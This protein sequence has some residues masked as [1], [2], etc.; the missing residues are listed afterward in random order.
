VIFSSPRLRALGTGTATL[1]LSATLLVATTTASAAQSSPRFSDLDETVHAE[2]IELVAEDGITSGYPDGTFRPREDVRRDQMAT[3]LA[4]ALRLERQASRFPDVPS[5]SPHNTAIGAIAAAD[6]TQGFADGT[7]R[8]L[9]NVT[10][11]QMATF[12]AKGLAL[13]PGNRTFSDVPSGYVHA[14]AISRLATAGITEGFPD[15]TFRPNELVKRDQMAAFLARGIPLPREAEEP[16]CP[17]SAGTSST[18]SSSA[19][20]AEAG[21]DDG[22]RAR[23]S[24]A[25]GDPDAPAVPSSERASEDLM[26][27]EQADAPTA[28]TSSSQ[29]PAVDRTNL[30]PAIPGVAFPLTSVLRTSA[31]TL[32]AHTQ[33]LPVS[34]GVRVNQRGEV[35]A[36]TT[37]PAGRRTW[38]TAQIGNQVYAGQQVASGDNLY[39]YSTAASGDRVATA[40]AEFPTGGEFWTLAAD[41]QDRL[42][43]GTR[44]HLNASV[45]AA[46]ELGNGRDDGRHVVHRI[47]PSSG[48]ATPVTFCMPDPFT[49]G[50]GV[51]ADVKQLASVGQTLYVGTGQLQGGA[52]L[53]A[54]EPG[55]REDV[56]LEDVRDLTPTNVRSATGIFAMRANAQYVAFGTQTTSGATARLVVIDRATERVRV[57]VAL[58]GETRV[59]AV[60]LRGDRVAAAGFS[61]RVYEAP[62]PASGTTTLT[63]HEPPVVDQ[64]HRFVELLGNGG[65]RGVT[66]RGVVWTLPPGG[67]PELANLVDTGAPAA[68][69]L[70]HSLHAGPT[71]VAVGGSSVITLRSGADG[72]AESRTVPIRGEAKA[73]TA[74]AAGDTY[75]AT[76]PNA[77]LWRLDAGESDAER[78]GSWTSQFLRPADADHDG[79]RDRERIHVV[80]RDDNNAMSEPREEPQANFQLRPS[81]LFSLDPSAPDVRTSGLAL[82]RANPHA[83]NVSATASAAAPIEASA[84]LTGETANGAEVYVGDTRGGV[85]RVHAETGTRRWYQA[86]ADGDSDRRVLGLDLIDGKLVVVTSGRLASRG[87]GPTYD[88]LTVIREIDPE[89]GTLLSRVVVVNNAGNSFQVGDAVTSGPV[90]VVT[91]R[92]SVRYVDRETGL[93]LGQ[94]HAT[95]DSFGGPYVA[96]D[97]ER[98]H[99]YFLE[100]VPADLVRGNVQLGACLPDDEDEDGVDDGDAQG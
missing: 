68:P 12:L 45:R 17:G 9:E 1:A 18:T 47:A 25:T 44:A 99:V 87:G 52:R 55:N 37:I 42:W 3:F 28:G 54:F 76:Y 6:I 70:P 4:N 72:D 62:I 94:A 95:N 15:G 65:L 69:G 75:A 51:R 89:D 40:V 50:A 71:D 46:V 5:D 66:Q 77:E 23:S 38:A 35:T 63:T 60:H 7:Y 64:F 53:Y 14:D 59:D 31:Q 24:E 30:G 22:E 36:T 90:T 8:P 32:E 27:L 100:D 29:V 85:Q 16:A 2:S 82:G 84:V 19:G 96:L 92:D 11:G 48:R 10:R 67:E 74:N 73:M 58:P 13:P 49:T 81:R 78:V 80:A 93:A 57:N 88:P 20:T 83:T 91:T 43:A 33:D 97:R 34:R 61:G 86:A 39:R 26:E 41:A 56:P 98:C 79:R 21:S